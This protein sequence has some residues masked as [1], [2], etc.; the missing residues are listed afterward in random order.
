MTLPSR[1]M[2]NFV[3]FHLMS[4]LARIVRIVLRQQV[5]QNRRQLVALVEA[6]RSPFCC[7]R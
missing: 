5:F 7:C 2:R 4:G 6:P 3:K 1:S